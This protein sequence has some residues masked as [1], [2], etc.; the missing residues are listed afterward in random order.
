MGEPAGARVIYLGL[1][2]CF[3]CIWHT[4]SLC[5]ALLVIPDRTDASS[6]DLFRRQRSFAS[7]AQ[8]EL[9]DIDANRR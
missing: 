3:D 8:L 4:A 1:P 9:D 7:A 5:H 6:C 2:D